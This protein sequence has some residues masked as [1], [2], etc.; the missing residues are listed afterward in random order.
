MPVP[1]NAVWSMLVPEHKRLLFLPRSFGTKL[2]L[3]GE[4]LVYSRM[5]RLAPT[6]SGGYWHF[7]EL[8]NDGFY[9]APKCGPLQICVDA[10]NDFC[11]AMSADAAGIVAVLFALNHLG[12]V[13]QDDRCFENYHRLLDFAQTHSESTLIFRA[14][15]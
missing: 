2:M 1:D 15:D 13:T 10:G 9:M 14:I 4:T 5:G 12:T 11:G 8:S 7:Y 3:R 6:Y